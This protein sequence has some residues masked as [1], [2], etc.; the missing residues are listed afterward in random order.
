MKDDGDTKIATFELYSPSFD[1]TPD[2]L[3]TRLEEALSNLN[4]N[5]L[6]HATFSFDR[7]T[8]FVRPRNDVYGLPVSGELLNS[9]GYLACSFS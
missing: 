9:R 6:V 1:S 2:L 8:V 4:P 7:D 3:K 5:D